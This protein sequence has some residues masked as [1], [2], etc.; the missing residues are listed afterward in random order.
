LHERAG[1]PKTPDTKIKKIRLFAE[2]KTGIYTGYIYIYIY[3][4][5]YLKTILQL[6]MESY[7]KP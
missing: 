6:L 5:I 4:F 1:I 2:L 7:G 3:I